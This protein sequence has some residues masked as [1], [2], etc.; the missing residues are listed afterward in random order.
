[1]CPAYKMCQ[2]KDRTET[3]GMANEWLAQIEAHSMGK[4]QSLTLWMVFCY[5]CRQECSK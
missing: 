2:D 4:I 5:A 1:M 3:E